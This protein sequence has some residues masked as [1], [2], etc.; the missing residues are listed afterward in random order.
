MTHSLSSVNNRPASPFAFGAMQFGQGASESDSKA[1]FD[2]CRTAGINHFDTAHGYTEGASETL[3]GAMVGDARD[4]LLIATKVG[5]TGDTSAANM[6]AEFDISRQRLNMDMVDIL[7][8][9]RF[10]PNT[11]LRESMQTLA[12]FRDKGQIR[13]VGLS[14]FAAWQV[15]K[16]QAAAQE[17][18]LKIDIFQPMYNLVKRQAEVEIMP[19][20]ADQGITVASYSPLGGGLLTGKYAGGA[21]GRL[22]ENSEYTMRYNVEW[23]RQTAQDLNTLAAD[24]GTHPAT[25]AVAWVAAHPTHP[26]P[27]LS[28]RNV[29]QLRPSLDGTTYD[30]TPSLYEQ[31]SALS[32][33][34]APATDR[35][36]E[37]G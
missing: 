32:V 27:I 11:E 1:M 22:V 29:G 31:I 33:T 35:L 37:V 16:A 10:D 8:L 26:T 5:N 12:E 20:C 7:Y 21:G 6:R 3:L 18:G 2:A 25:L 34:P 17:F 9:H 24:L 30:M 23:M 14:N 19:M 28:G 13:Y 15:M 36:E 4:D